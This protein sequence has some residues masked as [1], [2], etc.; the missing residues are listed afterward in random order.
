MNLNKNN[1]GTRCLAIVF[2]FIFFCSSCVTLTPR[3]KKLEPG[4]REFYLNVQLIMSKQEK[5]IYF[6]LPPEEREDFEK[7]FWETRDPTPFTEENEFKIEYF[8]RVATAKKAFWTDGMGLLGDRSRVY[9]IL[10]P[11]DD[12]RDY[13][14]IQSSYYRAAQKWIY[15]GRGF[16]VFF[17]DRNGTGKYELYYPDPLL[18]DFLNRSQNTLFTMGKGMEMKSLVFELDKKG[19]NLVVKVDT[20]TIAFEEEDEKMKYSL[21]VKITGPKGIILEESFKGAFQEKD[22]RA[23]PKHL[24]FTLPYKEN[25]KKSIYLYFTIYDRMGENI[26]S[27]ILR[28]KDI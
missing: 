10:G 2:L 16:V 23:F 15:T 9:I 21:E 8:K 17:V 4:S 1:R 12:S 3:F 24:E 22:S 5:D 13:P 18:M 20:S 7:R 11:P 25:I 28:G 14:V 19:N 6:S 26:G 27:K